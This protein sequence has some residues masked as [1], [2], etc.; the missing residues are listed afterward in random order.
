[1]EDLIRFNK[2]HTF[3]EKKLSPSFDVVMVAIA[4]PFLISITFALPSSDA[5]ASNFPLRSHRIHRIESRK[6]YRSLLM[7]ENNDFLPPWNV[8]YDAMRQGSRRSKTL[9]LRSVPPPTSKFASFG[10]V[11]IQ[12]VLSLSKSIY[13]KIISS[14]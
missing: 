9:I 4:F 10:Q 12:Y 7:I 1:M 8:P 5:L 11:S 14:N 6:V 13:Q 2:L 3:G